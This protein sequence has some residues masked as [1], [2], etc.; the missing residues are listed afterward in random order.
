MPPNS[1]YTV[2]NALTNWSSHVGNALDSYEN[3]KGNII[4]LTNKG[5][6]AHIT[7]TRRQTEVIKAINS[8]LFQSQL[9]LVA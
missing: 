6:K 9:Q 7:A 8:D 2:Y 4:Q 3:E 1:L 5:S